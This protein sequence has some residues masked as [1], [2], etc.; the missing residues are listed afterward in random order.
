MQVYNLLQGSSSWNETLLI[1]TYDEAGGTYDHQPP[2]LAT[3][4]AQVGMQEPSPPFPNIPA[5]CDPLF[6]AV[7]GFNFNVFG[8]RVPAII[9]SPWITPGSTIRAAQPFDHT[10]I[11]RTVLDTFLE[12][13]TS[14]TSRDAAAPSLIDCLAGAPSATTAPFGGVILPCPS[15]LV[16]EMHHDDTAT[17]TILVSAGST[18]PL[19]VSAMIL[20]THDDRQWLSISSTSGTDIAIRVTASAS[21]IWTGT[22][23]GQIEISGAGLTSITIPVTLIV[24]LL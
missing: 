4:P 13:K 22:F 10:S 14:L 5:A 9:I 17:Q 15:S 21:G 2:P 7:N 3:P 6:D 16:F 24:K 8:C 20:T 23:S 18:I 11:I 1:V 19:T 12:Q